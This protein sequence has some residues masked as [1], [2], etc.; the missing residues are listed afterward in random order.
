MLS[1]FRCR[2]SEPHFRCLTIFMI[3]GY[4]SFLYYFFFS[5]FNFFIPIHYDSLIMLLYVSSVCDRRLLFSSRIGY[6]KKMYENGRALS[7]I[8]YRLVFVWL[9]HHFA[10]LCEM[11]IVLGTGVLSNRRCRNIFFLFFFFNF[12]EFSDF[13]L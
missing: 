13:L 10:V 6:G 2:D 9:L 1:C 5:S 8:R 7:T 11:G 4:S 3:T 12:S